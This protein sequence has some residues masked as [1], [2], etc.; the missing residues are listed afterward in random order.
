MV[1]DLNAAPGADDLYPLVKEID[2]PDPI[3][4][5]SGSSVALTGSHDDSVVFISGD[6]ILVVPVQ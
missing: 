1:H 4:V 5:A 3:F 2:V 6:H